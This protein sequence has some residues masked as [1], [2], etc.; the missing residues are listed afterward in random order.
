MFRINVG[1]AWTGAEI[2]HIDK[3]DIIIKDARPFHAGPPKGYPDLTGWRSV[4]ITPDMVG[5]KIAVFVA[6]EVKT[7][8]GRPTKDQESFL[9]QVIDAG[10]IAGVVRSEDDVGGLLKH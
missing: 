9:A 7:K 10:G 5:E 8:K 3:S 4:T 6:V 2:I 1:R